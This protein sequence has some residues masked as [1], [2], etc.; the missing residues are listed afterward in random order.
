MRSATA[1]AASG[2]ASYLSQIMR[3]MF[4][5]LQMTDLMTNTELSRVSY[6]GVSV[7]LLALPIMLILRGR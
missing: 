2:T 1:A 6:F 7:A 5:L 3:K 4:L